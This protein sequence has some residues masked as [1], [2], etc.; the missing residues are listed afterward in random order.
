MAKAL[1]FF[2]L[3]FQILDNG[4]RDVAFTLVFSFQFI[5]HPELLCSSSFLVAELLISALVL[6]F[7][8]GFSQVLV[9]AY[10]RNAAKMQQNEHNLVVFGKGNRLLTVGDGLCF[11]WS[12]RKELHCIYQFGSLQENLADF[13]PKEEM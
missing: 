7:L 8:F 1:V 6:L 9:G 3:F 12:K 11:C 4:N 2:P 13:P 5:F 10:I